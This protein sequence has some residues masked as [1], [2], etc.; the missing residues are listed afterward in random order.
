MVVCTE[1]VESRDL[2][3]SRAGT[4]LRNWLTLIR[5][6]V[7]KYLDVVLRSLVL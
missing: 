2:R 7:I 4:S 6:F 1:R 5:T 3:G